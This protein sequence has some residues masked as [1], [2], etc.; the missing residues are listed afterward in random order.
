VQP[1][2]WLQTLTPPG[3][4]SGCHQMTGNHLGGSSR[5]EMGAFAGSRAAVLFLKKS[6]IVVAPSEGPPHHLAGCRVLFYRFKY[7]R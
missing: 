3:H 4:T 5:H 2:P 6:G 7:V 1:R